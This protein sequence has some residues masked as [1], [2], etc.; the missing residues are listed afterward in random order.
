MKSD[1]L[2]EGEG[3]YGFSETALSP[4]EYARIDAERATSWRV[5]ADKAIARLS[6]LW[7]TDPEA[8]VE[9]LEDRMGDIRFMDRDA[10]TSDKNIFV[11]RMELCLAEEPEGD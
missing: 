6:A 3:F 1:N 7:D 8:A 2:N 4:E 9:G 5:I 11:A 10:L